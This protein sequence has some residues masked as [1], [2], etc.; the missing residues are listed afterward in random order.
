[1]HIKHIVGAALVGLGLVAGVADA[2]SIDQRHAYQQE[3]IHQGERSGQ[4]TYGEARRM[5]RQ[6]HK[7]YRTEARER[8][9]NGGYLT[10]GERARMQARENRLSH[11]IYNN[12][13]NYRRY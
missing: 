9:R 2:Q 12:K 8:Y 3:R 4:L 5:E 7:L 1:M 6:Q 10:R 11:H 13:H